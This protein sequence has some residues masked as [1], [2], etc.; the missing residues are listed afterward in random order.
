MQRTIIVVAMLVAG[1]AATPQMTPQPAE[2]TPLP[3]GSGALA[4]PGTPSPASTPA[5]LAGRILFLRHVDDELT[6]YSIRPDGSELKTLEPTD[7]A[8]RRMSP[9]GSMFVEMFLEDGHFAKIFASDGSL[10]RTLDLPDPALGLACLT[11][12][13]DGARLACEGWDATNPGEDLKPD[14]V[15]LYTVQ[16]DG[17]DL[18]QLTSPADHRH[19]QEPQYSDDG[20]Q[21]RYV[22]STD[23]DGEL[24]ELWAINVDGTANQRLISDPVGW[25]TDLSPDGRWLATKLNGEL[26][27]YDA[28]DWS[29]PPMRHHLPDAYAWQFSW[30]PDGSHVAFM[31]SVVALA[32]NGIGTIAADGTGFQILPTG[33]D[34]GLID[35]IGWLP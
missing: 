34:P 23:E 33:S 27:I 13:P 20:L 4:S 24:G 12:S 2:A 28:S 1:C 9:D 32:D 26:A 17:G 22:H 10:I 31:A 3:H 18:R 11:W 8:L 14:R 15:G 6:F 30:S 29:M 21:I 35:L 7:P 5:R 16:V 25:T 19:D